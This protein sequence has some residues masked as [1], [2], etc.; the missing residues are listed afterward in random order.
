M[1]NLRGASII[2]A[3]RFIEETYKSEGLDK[4]LAS[5]EEEDRKILKGKLSP[6]TF[7]PMRLFINFSVAADR[8]FGSG[9]YDICRQI[10]YYEANETFS[11]IYKVFLDLTNPLY[12][13]SHAGMAWKMVH[14]FGELKIEQV[15]D[16]YVRGKISDFPD[17]HKAHCV[18]LVGYFTRVLELCGAKDVDVK[19]VRC[20]C[21]G[22]DYCEFEV[23]WS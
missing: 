23:K 2:S 19:E 7:Y 22:S 12:V 10:G 20:I 16:K 17:C 8:L 14:D 13:I 18:D 3:M 9:D 21:N 4:V 5:L 6:M 1:G 11:G 15:N